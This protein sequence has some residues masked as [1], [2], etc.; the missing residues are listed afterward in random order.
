MFAH[1]L[2]RCRLRIHVGKRGAG[3][4]D[5][6]RCCLA[7]RLSEARVAGDTYADNRF[8]EVV[9]KSLKLRA[10]VCHVAPHQFGALHPRKLLQTPDTA[11]P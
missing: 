1:R 8:V 5:P 7:M 10:G 4:D 9:L 2:T 3:R 11:Q 6:C